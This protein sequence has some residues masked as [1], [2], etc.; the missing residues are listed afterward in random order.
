MER[1][2][3]RTSVY[4]D[5][6][7]ELVQRNWP[8][9]WAR[10]RAQRWN[11]ET[12]FCDYLRDNGHLTTPLGQVLTN[13]HLPVGQNRRFIDFV[14]HHRGAVPVEKSWMGVA[15]T[16]EFKGLARHTLFDFQPKWF[17]RIME[18]IGKQ[19][20]AAAAH[21]DI[22]QYFICT[23]VLDSPNRKRAVKLCVESA[24]PELSAEITHK[25]QIP[26][27][28]VV[29]CGTHVFSEINTDMFMFLWRIAGP[30][31]A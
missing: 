7:F 11:Q 8:T 25:L 28:A 20:E 29:P 23:A 1:L 5:A 6:F 4:R 9:F 24:I 18:D 15:A 17:P 14:M 2:T 22:E 26:K 3:A 30:L 16:C 21:P 10:A 27:S 13:F 12:A 31:R 19:Y